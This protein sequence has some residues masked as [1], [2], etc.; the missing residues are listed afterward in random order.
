MLLCWNYSGLYKR[1][2]SY[3]I[4]DT[5]PPSPDT[6]P[7][8]HFLLIAPTLGA[9]WFFDA[10]R[11]YWERFRPTVVSD[12]EFVRLIPPPLTVAVTVL[13]RRDTATQWGVTL[14]Q[15]APD[16]LFDPIVQDQFDNAKSALNERAS[17]NQP[18]G[19]PLLPTPTP[20][21]PISPTPGSI[22]GPVTVP[23]RPPGGFITA[24]PT[25]N[26]DAPPAATPTPDPNAGGE[27]GPIYPTPGPITGGG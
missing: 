13:A 21:A 7:D 8:Y 10:A 26:P 20:P 22:I 11:Q 5:M 1:R 16:A 19:V 2:T 9:E 3:G 23:T 15:A 17:L 12:L 18:F 24:T 27:Q 25:I 4:M 6:L 14:A